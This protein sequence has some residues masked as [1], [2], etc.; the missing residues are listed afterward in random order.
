MAD[1]PRKGAMGVKGKLCVTQ[2]GVVAFDGFPPHPCAPASGTAASRAQSERRPCGTTRNRHRSVAKTEPRLSQTLVKLL[3]SDT[4][5][6]RREGK[7][8]F[9]L[10][11]ACWKDN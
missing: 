4:V 1:G 6:N 2:G 3:L 7:P 5:D 8:S 11:S 9:V 10:W